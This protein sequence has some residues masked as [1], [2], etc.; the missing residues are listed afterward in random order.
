MVR[1]ASR[2]GTER[3]SDH[4]AYTAGMIRVHSPLQDVPVQDDDGPLLYLPGSDCALE[5]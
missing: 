5:R 2:R 1:I 3:W 4:E